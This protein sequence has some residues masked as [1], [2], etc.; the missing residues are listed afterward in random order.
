MSIIKVIIGVGLLG[1]AILGG[2]VVEEYCHRLPTEEEMSDY[3]ASH[4]TTKLIKLESKEYIRESDG[5]E[6]IVFKGLHKPS[7]T[8]EVYYVEAGKRW[9]MPW[10]EYNWKSEDKDAEE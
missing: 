8:E 9:V 1:L 6:C 5:A 7:G 3:H 2:K 10:Q 4:F